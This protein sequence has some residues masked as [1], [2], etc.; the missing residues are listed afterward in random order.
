MIHIVPAA[1]GENIEKFTEGS[2]LRVEVFEHPFIVGFLDVAVNKV[3]P[4]ALH[5]GLDYGALQRKRTL[6]DHGKQDPT[7]QEN[8]D[9][10]PP[11][12]LLPLD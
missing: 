3:Q 11:V 6:L 9:R 1:V 7:N 10:G 4:T 12:T 2:S 5:Q 8:R